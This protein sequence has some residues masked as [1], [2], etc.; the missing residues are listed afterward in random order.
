MHHHGSEMCPIGVVFQC[1]QNTG[2][3]YIK[4]LSSVVVALALLTV[5]T[6]GS[7]AYKGRHFRIYH[8]PINAKWISSYPQQ[9]PSVHVVV[10]H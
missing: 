3:Q 8:S 5:R 1:V 6:L 4:T 10:Q 9:R 7:E 2:F